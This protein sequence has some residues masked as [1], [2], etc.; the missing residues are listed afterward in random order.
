[1]KVLDTGQS[2]HLASA[3]KRF[4]RAHGRV[5]MVLGFMQWFWYRNDKRREKF[6]TLCKDADVQRL[7]WESYLNKKL[8]R[9]DPMGHVRVFIKDM[10][11][12]LRPA[13]H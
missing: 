6:V 1:M 13:A 5:F 7:T 10:R 11:Q 9:K 8:V 3:R 12:L 4:Q 2:R